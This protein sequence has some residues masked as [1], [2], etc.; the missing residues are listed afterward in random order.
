MARRASGPCAILYLLFSILFSLPFTGCVPVGAVFNKV[1]GTPPVQAQ[2]VPDRTKLML[3]L[4]ESFRNPDAG[5]IDAQRVTMQVVEEL[6][7]YHVAPV[8]DPEDVEALRSRPAYRSMKVEEIGRAAGARQV[9]YVNLQPVKVDNTVASEMLRAR[10]EMLVRVVDVDT[11]QTLWPYDAPQGQTLVAESPWV[12]S[13][14]G[15]RE[16]LPERE[17]RDQVARSAA[18]Q[19][20]KLFRKWSPDDEEQEL[21]ETVR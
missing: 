19:I 21:E 2:Y 10:A 14:A 7:R 3:V 17:L 16:G 1:V 12:R 9:L 4:V 6:R 11:G 5:R 18:H 8:V 13:P 20:V 15:G